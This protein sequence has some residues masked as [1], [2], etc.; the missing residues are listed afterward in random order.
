MKVL[1]KSLNNWHI[2]KNIS[3]YFWQP[4]L[5]NKLYSIEVIYFNF[6]IYHYLNKSN[7]IESTLKEGIEVKYNIND[8]IKSH[9]IF[10]EM[11]IDINNEKKITN[12]K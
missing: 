5:I 9:L 1:I 2:S 8:V 3:K 4:P 7:Y 10:D 11:I 12:N 6:D